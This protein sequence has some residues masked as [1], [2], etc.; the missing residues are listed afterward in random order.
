MFLKYASPVSTMKLKCYTIFM[1]NFWY[2]CIMKCISVGGQIYVWLLHPP[3]RD[4]WKCPINLPRF[5]I[6]PQ[7]NEL[8]TGMS[9]AVGERSHRVCVALGVMRFVRL[10][11]SVLR[12]HTWAADIDEVTPGPCVARPGASLCRLAD[13]CLCW[14]LPCE[15]ARVTWQSGSECWPYALI[16]NTSQMP[17]KQKQNK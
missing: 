2:I 15:M 12:G 1:L 4:G 5:F 16:V 8:I 3:S 14:E 11:W 13:S 6:N 17:S 7:P 9:A 10:A